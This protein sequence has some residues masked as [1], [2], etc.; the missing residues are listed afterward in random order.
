MWLPSLNAAQACLM[1]LDLGQLANKSPPISAT[2]SAFQ[3]A[4]F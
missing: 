3:R 1:A 4:V 2:V